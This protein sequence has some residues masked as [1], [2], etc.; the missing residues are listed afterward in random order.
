MRSAI[1][2]LALALTGCGPS[3]Y[4]DFRDQLAN[5]WCER[6]VRCGEVGGGESQKC[7]VPAVLALTIPGALDVVA[8]IGANR[9][10]FH[11][12]NAEECLKA[13]TNAPCDQSQAADEFSR[14]CHGVVGAKVEVDGDCFGSEECVGG[15]CVGDPC[16]GKCVAYASPGSACLATGGK[17]AET[18]D[19]TVHYCDGTCKRK[20]QAD[21]ACAGDGECAFDNV[22]ADGKCKQPPRLGR[23]DVCGTRSPPCE[24]GLYCDESG[25]CQPLK[26]TGE[27]CVRANACDDGLVCEAGMCATWLDLG[28][29]CSATMPSGCPSSQ[30]CVAGSCVAADVKAGP[31]SICSVDDDCADGLWCSM[32]YCLYRGGVNAPCTATHECLDGLECNRMLCKTAAGASCPEF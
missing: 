4:S 14:H 26:S 23:D 20:K 10:R 7:G 22:C 29:S 31:I 9:M 2:I 13:V 12:D 21:E 32:G 15:V 1:V 8:A 6:E 3:S 19:P 16:A 27:A 24:D 25:S 5:R 30:K 11:P 18:C 17:P 28:G